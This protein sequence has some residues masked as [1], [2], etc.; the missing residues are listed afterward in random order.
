MKQSNFQKFCQNHWALVDSL[1]NLVYVDETEGA[2]TNNLDSLVC[3]DEA[4]RER[5]LDC[6]ICL[7]ETKKETGQPW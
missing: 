4:K 1:D 7:L 3:L 6:L 2:W 5:T